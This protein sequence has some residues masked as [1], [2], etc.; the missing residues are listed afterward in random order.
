MTRQE[1]IQNRNRYRNAVAVVVLIFV[2]LFWG[3]IFLMAWLQQNRSDSLMNIWPALNV[4]AFAIMVA[5]FSFL[6]IRTSRL[7]TRFGLR[8]PECKKPVFGMSRLVIA[9]GRCGHC[10]GK[11]LDDTA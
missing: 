2:F 5:A 8:C 3:T 6:W 11:V 1:F 7:I 4:G 9:T 10:G